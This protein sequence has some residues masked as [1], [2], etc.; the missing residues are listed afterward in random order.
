MSTG[1][2]ENSGGVIQVFTGISEMNVDAVIMS[3]LILLGSPPRHAYSIQSVNRGGCYLILFA[4]SRST[5]GTDWVELGHFSEFLEQDH[6][7]VNYTPDTVF[8]M[9][10]QRLHAETHTA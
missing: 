10:S 5:F 8:F 2:R 7:P 1:R 6:V 4:V 3:S 9:Q